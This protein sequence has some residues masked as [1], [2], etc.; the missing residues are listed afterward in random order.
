[1]DGLNGS[2]WVKVDGLDKK[3]MVLIES[4]PSKMDFY[5]SEL[6][7]IGR[8]WFKVDRHKSGRFWWNVDG[9]SSNFELQSR[10]SKIDG[11]ESEWSR[12]DHLVKNDQRYS[13]MQNKSGL[14][15]FPTAQRQIW[16]WQ[17]HFV[18]I[19]D[20]ALFLFLA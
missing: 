20:P 17:E 6:V 12:N 5:E 2:S 19:L 14:I 15:V 16:P 4:G 7:E 11:H 18:K 9:L 13:L 10:Q 3:W 1:M 8:S